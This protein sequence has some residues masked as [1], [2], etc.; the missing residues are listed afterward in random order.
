M[1]MTNANKTTDT[2]DAYPIFRLLNACS[3]K[4]QTIMLVDPIGPPWVMTA[5][6][7]NTLNE[8]MI[9]VIPIAYNISLIGPYDGWNNTCHTIAT[10]TMLEM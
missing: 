3:Y 8:E 9:P 7:S 5:M 2:E 4:Y 1:I 6:I 10:A